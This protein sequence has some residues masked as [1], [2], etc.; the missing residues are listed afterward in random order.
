MAP[1]NAEKSSYKKWEIQYD[2]I[3][4]PCAKFVRTKNFKMIEVGTKIWYN[5]KGYELLYKGMIKYGIPCGL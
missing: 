1:E 2:I 3:N 4:K 5:K